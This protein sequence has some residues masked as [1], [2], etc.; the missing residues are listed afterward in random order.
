MLERAYMLA[1][2]FSRDLH[3]NTFRGYWGTWAAGQRQGEHSTYP[4]VMLWGA[5]GH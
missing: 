4:C 1:Q 3:L 2:F 5:C